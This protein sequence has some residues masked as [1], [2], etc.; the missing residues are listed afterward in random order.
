[1]TII[2]AIWLELTEFPLPDTSHGYRSI[3]QTVW[4]VLSPS[5]ISIDNRIVLI[6][7]DNKNRRIMMKSSKV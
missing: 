1:M 7:I 4:G 5:L 2:F 6:S 3:H